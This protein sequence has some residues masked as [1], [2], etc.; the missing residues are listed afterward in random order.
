MVMVHGLRSIGYNVGICLDT[1]H[2]WSFGVDWHDPARFDGNS[3]FKF[4]ADIGY[5][6][7]IHL[8]NGPEKVA[9]GSNY[10]RHASITQGVI[11]PDALRQ[12]LD[13]FPNIPVIFERDS[14]EG[15]MSDWNWLKSIET[16]ETVT[17]P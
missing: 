2:A 15:V 16:N 3:V 10:D 7:L 8:N 4:L 12:V 1:L 9:C 11:N 5:V 13:T 17:S 6:Q 14:Y